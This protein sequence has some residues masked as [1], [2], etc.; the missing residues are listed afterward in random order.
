VFGGLSTSVAAVDYDENNLSICMPAD[1]DGRIEKATEKSVRFASFNAFL[2][3]STEGQ[4]IADLQSGND[5]QI[6]AVAE[7]IQRTR[8]DV[9]LINEFDFDDAKQAADLFRTHYLQVKQNG[10][11]YIEYPY[12]YFAESNTGLPSGVDLDGNGSVGGP[13]DA[14][15]FGFFPGQFA[16]VLYSKYPILEDEV[17]TF[18][19]F[20]WKDMPNSLL[21]GDY[22]SEAAQAVFRLS[23][24][25]HWDIPLAIKGRTVHVLAAH[26][27]PPVFDG[28]EDRNGRRNHDEIRFW[29]DYIGGKKR[30]HYIYDDQGEKG[31]LD[32][33]QAF[34]IM[35]DYN[36]DPNDGD[37]TDRA[38]VQL[39]N[40]KAVDV[41]RAPASL[42][43][44][45]DAELEGNANDMHV[46]N[47]ALD[48]GD[49]NPAGPGNLR[50]DYVVP[51]KKGL[52]PQ[53]GG[54]FWPKESDATRYL[55]GAG[56]PVVSSDH[57][58]VW[59]DIEVK[60]GR[61]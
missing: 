60:R 53:C 45:E 43:G 33:N 38:I 57:H 2:N 55:V 3:R 26:P 48:T 8:P 5:P 14:F 56:F 18:Q 37:S 6:Q 22:Y 61:K 28:P 4:L 34:V 10:Q 52:K 7:I 23:S 59:Y 30:S 15:G 31:G 27:T 49:F 44:W 39:L 13:N 9:L 24:K 32:R 20:L 29:A 16:M 51:S 35:G 17:R 21:P 12:V 19:K 42:G 1:L 36:A 25:S 58:L 40:H 47:A 54:V 50:V 11:P 46:G 41:T